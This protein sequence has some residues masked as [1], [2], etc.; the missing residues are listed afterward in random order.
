[1]THERDANEALARGIRPPRREPATQ[2]YRINHTPR[3]APSL[4]WFARLCRALWRRC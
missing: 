1:M 2:R 3:P 4:G